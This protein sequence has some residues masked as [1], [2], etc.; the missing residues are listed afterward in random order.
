MDLSKI[1]DVV[2]WVTPTT[3]KEV[4]GFLGLAGYYRRF[5]PD[6]SKI[7]KPLTE[8]TKKDEPYVWTEAREEAFQTLKK[9][10]VT[11]PVLVQPDITKPFEVYCDAPNVGLG[12]VLMQDGHV[13]AYASRQLKDSEVNYPTHDLELAAVVHALKVWRHYLFGQP[14]TI[15]TDHKSLRYFFTQLELNMRQR[16]WLE[17]IKDYDLNIQYHPGKANVVANALSRK[18][19][20]GCTL[21]ERN[22]DSLCR[23]MQMI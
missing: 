2:E 16:R 13:I 17:L 12:C 14:C 7:A 6:F 19:N 11:A 5:V 8:L 22:M 18:V 20:C 23:Y 1:K 10:L 21:M 15:F 9:R 3:V 4:R